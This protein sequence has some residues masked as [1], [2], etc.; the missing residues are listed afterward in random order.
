MSMRRQIL[1]ILFWVAA[2]AVDLDLSNE[3]NPPP[4][5]PRVGAEAWEL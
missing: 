5:P 2:L 3:I 1:M 4:D